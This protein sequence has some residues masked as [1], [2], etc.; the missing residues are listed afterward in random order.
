[1]KKSRTIVI[2]V[3]VTLVV[4]FV[5]GALIKRKTKKPDEGPKVRIE[6]PQRGELIEFV[7]APGE[8]EPR[9]KVAISAKVSARITELPFDE[10]DVVTLQTDLNLARIEDQVSGLRKS[11]GIGVISGHKKRQLGQARH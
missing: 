4:V 11:A 5:L 2:T 9:K 10:G 8:I 7:S 3:I 1:M 6:Q